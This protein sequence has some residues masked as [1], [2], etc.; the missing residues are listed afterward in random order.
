VAIHKYSFYIVCKKVFSIQEKYRRNVS[1]QEVQEEWAKLS[2]SKKDDYN[3]QARAKRQK[4][5]IQTISGPR[6]TNS[7]ISEFER[8]RRE[9]LKTENDKTAD[10]QQA[11]MAAEDLGELDEKIF[12]IISMESFYEDSRDIFP[13]EF[14]MAKF[15]LKEGLFDQ[16]QIRINP[17]PLPLGA[18]RL[19]NERSNDKHKYPVPRDHNYDSRVEEGSYILILQKIIEFIHPLSDLPMF[20]AEGS[21]DGNHEALF[22]TQRAFKK[23]FSQACEY[24]IADELKVYSISDL[25]YFLRNSYARRMEQ[26]NNE[27][28]HKFANTTTAHETFTRAEGLHLYNISGCAYHHEMDC[29]QHC[30]LSKVRRYCYIIA[31]FCSNSINYPL[32]EGR[33]YP[34]GYLAKT[35]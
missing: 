1:Y 4:L 17:G 18:A 15:S 16:M 2:G 8:K 28:V 33:H 22:N 7:P 5:G 9:V 34:K 6:L 26:F 21:K 32:V 24:Q 11:V 31:N 25:F 12:Y 13:C 20:F 30:C 29:I 3:E 23:I 14:A 19:A 27:I 10:I 35:K